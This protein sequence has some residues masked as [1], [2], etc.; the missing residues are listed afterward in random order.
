MTSRAATP[1]T[2]LVEQP[3]IELFAELGW[4]TVNAYH[5][6][7]GADGH[8]RTREPARGRPAPRLRDGARAAE[9]RRCPP[10]RSTR[11]IERAH[12][13]PLRHGSRSAPTARSTSCCRDGVEGRRPQTR[14]A[15]DAPRRVRVID[16]DDPA[17]NDFLLVSQ[18]WVTGDLYKRR[19]DLVGFVNGLPLVFI[20]LKAPHRRPASTPTTT[21]SR[22]YRDTIPQLFWSN[23]LHHPLQRRRD[24]RSGT[25]HRRLGA[26]RRVEEDRR[27]GRAGRRLAGDGDPRHVRPGPPARPGRELHRSSRSARAGWSSSSRKNHQYLGVNNAIDAAAATSTSNQGRLGVFWHTQGSGQEPLDGV[28]RAEGAAQ[29]RRATG[30]S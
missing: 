15:A 2:Q 20:E 18:F 16:W 9:P 27:R 14:T 22:D 26:L 8:A 7:F 29:D 24:A 23:A 21:T 1:R 17:N 13:G 5:E 25:H 28:L 30:P 10:R 6:T 12:Q 11:P 19:A 4:E 3:A